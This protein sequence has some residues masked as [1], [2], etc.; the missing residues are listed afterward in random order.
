MKMT[1]TILGGVLLVTAAVHLQ[2]LPRFWFS[3]ANYRVVAVSSSYWLAWGLCLVTLLSS[4]LLFDRRTYRTGGSLACGLF[5]VFIFAQLQALIRGLEIS[6]GSFG[7]NH[8]TEVSGYSVCI[9]LIGLVASTWVTWRAS[10]L[11]ARSDASTGVHEDRVN[12]RHDDRSDASSAVV[13]GDSIGS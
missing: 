2:N 4:S 6:C 12:C 1:A 8:S 7:A 11:D 5:A 13:A 9:S 3:I 10:S